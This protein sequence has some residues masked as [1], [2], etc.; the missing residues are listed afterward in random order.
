MNSKIIM[1]SITV[2]LKIPMADHLKEFKS[3]S[4]LPDYVIW[5]T[6]E[7]S[8]NMLRT[9]AA[10]VNFPMSAED[11]NDLSLLEQKFDNEDG[12]ARLLQS[13]LAFL[14]DL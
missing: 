10:V 6:D 3:Q 1:N 5:Q 13:K 14:K 7:A 4:T 2:K 11:K 8:N 9:K 12:C